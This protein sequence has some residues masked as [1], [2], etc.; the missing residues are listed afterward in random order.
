MSVIT[1][2]SSTIARIGADMKAMRVSVTDYGADPTLT[3]V[4]NTP[5][6]AAAIAALNTAGG[7]TLHIPRGRFYLNATQTINFSNVI[8][9]G[10]GKTATILDFQNSVA[11][12]L[13]VTRILDFH[14]RDFS[15]LNTTGNGIQIGVTVGPQAN[16]G[17]FTIRDVATN[18]TGGDGILFGQAFMGDIC[19]MRAQ[20]ASNDGISMTSGFSTSLDFNNCHAMDAG[21]HGWNI[22][23]CVYTTLDSCGADRSGE[24]GYKIQNVHNLEII[25]GC[26]ESGRAAIGF[27]HDTLST[28]LAFGV[29]GVRINMFEK[30][31]NSGGL[32][33]ALAEFTSNVGSAYCGDVVFEG[34]THYNPPAGAAMAITSGNWRINAPRATNQIE[35]NITGGSFSVIGDGAGDVLNGLPVNVTGPNTPIANLR[36]KMTNGVL[37]Y[38]GRVTVYVTNNNLQSSAR[39]ATYELLIN[40]AVGTSG[41]TLIAAAGNT[42]GATADSASFTFILD[43]ANNNLEVS[44]VGSTATGNWYFHFSVSGNLDIEPL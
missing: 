19:G 7:G 29:K 15:I 24:H 40:R 20:N 14:L 39:S 22:K 16:A 26:E 44:P 34:C 5:A 33:A 23:N 17:W 6:F 9:E 42:T 1:S 4:E 11:V 13:D 28:D 32:S 25:A 37:A 3:A 31:N 12:G 41:V 38:G 8:I 43:V 36:P 10:D 21:Q 18:F 27:E 35:R 2:L 30:D